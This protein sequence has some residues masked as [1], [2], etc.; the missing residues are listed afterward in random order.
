MQNLV[1]NIIQRTALF[2]LLLTLASTLTLESRPPNRQESGLK[3]AR[4]KYEGGGDW[5]NDRSAEVNLLRYV[6]E[7]TSIQVDP[8][9]ESV[10]LTSDRIFNYPLLFLTGHGNVRFAE[11]EIDYLR[12]Y[13]QNG[14]FLYIDDDYGLDT[15]IRR[16]MKRVFPAQNFK[17]LSFKH[18]IYHAFFTFASGPPKTHEHDGKAPQGFGLFDNSG[19]LAVYYTY[20]TNPSDGWADPEVHND[21]PEKRE[22]ALQFGTNIVVYVLTH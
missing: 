17:E 13:L 12:S 9:F 16:E 15:A 6:S 10:E 20:E 22:T 18:P 3:I 21:P 14:G 2:V 8:G 7:K 5:Y 11:R 1:Q 19:R 4:V